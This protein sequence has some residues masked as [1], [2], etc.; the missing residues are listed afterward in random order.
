MVRVIDL[1][2][3][4]PP[5]ASGPGSG[6]Q[7]Q[8]AAGASAVAAA[9][10]PNLC[11][12]K[13]Y[14]LCSRGH[15]GEGEPKEQSVRCQLEVA[16]LALPVLLSRSE[17]ILRRYAAEDRHD[18]LQQQQQEPRASASGLPAA[19][20]AGVTGAAVLLLPRRLPLRTSRSR[21]SWRRRGTWP[22]LLQQLRVAPAVMDA[23]VASARP[24]LRAWLD[25]VRARKRKA[26]TAVAR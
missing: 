11:L 10:F 12:S 13:L 17:A 19:S 1:G 23:A 26:G 14:V 3:R 22:E 8:P 20:A 5:V 25:V 16:Q 15:G 7:Q 4:S 21:C 18:S 6:P 9:R 24:Q 2:T